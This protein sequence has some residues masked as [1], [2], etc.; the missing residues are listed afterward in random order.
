[1]PEHQPVNLALNQSTLEDPLW[2]AALDGMRIVPRPGQ[3][4]QLDFPIFTSGEIDGTI[5]LVRNDITAP[6][7]RV[8]VEVVDRKGRVVKT[9]RTEYDGFYVISNIPLGEYTV[10]VSPTQ[11]RELNLQ[12]EDVPTISISGDNQFESGVD[13][14]LSGVAQDEVVNQDL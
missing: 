11:M 13:F 3:A 6:A 8:L 4:M 9:T 1:M 5:Y 10:R 2:T 7:G 12:A 14:T